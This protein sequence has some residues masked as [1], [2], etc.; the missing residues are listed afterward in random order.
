M[1]DRMLV[2]NRFQVKISITETIKKW[3]KKFKWL[4][5][6]ANWQSKKN[7]LKQT[8]LASAIEEIWQ[9]LSSLVYQPQ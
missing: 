7:W 9:P 3:K 6:V 2:Y 4:V 5:R 1:D 8:K